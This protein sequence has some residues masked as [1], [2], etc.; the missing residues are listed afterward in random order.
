[1]AEYRSPTFS[2]GL[3]IDVPENSQVVMHWTGFGRSSR[4][5]A[6]EVQEVPLTMLPAAIR[7][8]VRERGEKD[9]GREIYRAMAVRMQWNQNKIKVLCKTK[10][11]LGHRKGS[12]RMDH[13]LAPSEY[14]RG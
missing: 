11:A 14:R 10:K 7:Y 13:A 1:M 4:R 9:R 8:G 2:P 3:Q 12:H 5:Q 6:F